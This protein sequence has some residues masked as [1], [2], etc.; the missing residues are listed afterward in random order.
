MRKAVLKYRLI[1][2]T[3]GCY[4]FGPCDPSGEPTKNYKVTGFGAL[5]IDKQLVDDPDAT[6]IVQIVAEGNQ[7]DG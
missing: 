6:L 3:K 4:T 7:T 1:S 5:Y 2:E